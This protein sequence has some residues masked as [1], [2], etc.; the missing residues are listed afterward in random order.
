MAVSISVA[1]L[2]ILS[3]P[4]SPL[5][6][7][8]MLDP[9]IA[10][11]GVFEEQHSVTKPLPHSGRSHSASSGHSPCEGCGGVGWGR[12]SWDWA[13]CDWLGGVGGQAPCDEGQ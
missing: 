5:A 3:V 2:F 1:L 7:L 8:T 9:E 13:L 11:V 6:A 10:A 12:V 4:S